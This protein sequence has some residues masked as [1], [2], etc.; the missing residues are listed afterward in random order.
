MIRDPSS[1]HRNCRF[2]RKRGNAVIQLTLSMSLLL[3]LFLGTWEFGYGFYLYS[4]LSEAVRSGAR[5]ASLRT[6][7]SATSTPSATFTT[8]VQNM[9]VYGD[10]T[11]TNTTPVV[12]GLTTNNV[13]VG[14]TFTRGVPTAVSVAISGFRLPTYF[15]STTLYNAPY[16]WFP[17]VGVFGPP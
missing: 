6:Y 7:D 12:V 16:V 1:S 5:Y 17:Y 14:C 8:A 15:G 11:G 3:P 13:T 9:V 2:H 4:Q 10:P